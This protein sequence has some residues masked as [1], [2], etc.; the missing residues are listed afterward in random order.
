MQ[1]QGLGK[2]LPDFQTS[3]ERSKV[4]WPLSADYIALGSR[5]RGTASSGTEF[6]STRQPWND[7]FNEVGVVVPLYEN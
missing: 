6:Y 3:V 2:L 4:I 1:V 5:P 7:M